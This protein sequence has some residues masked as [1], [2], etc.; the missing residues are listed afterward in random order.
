[1]G[2]GNM[3]FRVALLFPALAQAAIW[4]DTIGPYHRAGAMPVTLTDRAV[5][6]EYG[7]KNSEAARYEN[8]AS[9]FT[10]TAYFLQDSTGALAA[11][12]WQRAAS[13]TP[14]QAAPIAAETA[15]GLLLLHGN[16]LLSFTGYKPAPEELSA[17]TASLR[18]VDDTSLP[19][20]RGFFP[21]MDLVPNSERY[22]IGPA[23]LQKFAPA[24]P[25]S[26]AA[27]HF[28]AEG[29]TGVFRSPKGE[30]ALAEAAAEG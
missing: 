23:S 1:M 7:L 26:V 4:P 28:G 18:N 13:S 5:W 25:P 2:W 6:D 14:S 22:I 10:A 12:D 24:I 11:F 16:Y 19:A 20:L 8:D 17:L 9:G 15:G 27:F 3:I 30:I 21:S 29:Q